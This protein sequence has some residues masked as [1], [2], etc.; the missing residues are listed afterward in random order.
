[1][2]RK[3]SKEEEV[4][5]VEKAE[6][7]S[8]SKNSKL[9]LTMRE[10]NKKFGE[11]SI[12]SMDKA[13]HTKVKVIPTGS[14]SLDLALGVGG[15]PRGRII[16]IYGPES[17]GKTTLTLSI[18]ASAQSKGLTV[19]YIDAE[20]AMDTSYAQKVGVD[21]SKLKFAQ[22]N[23]GE[24]ALEILEALTKSGTIGLII[25]DSVAALIPQKEL[26]GEMGD[27]TMGMQARLMSQAM[28]KICG[29]A[30]DTETCIIFINQLRANI[31][32]YGNPEVTSG[33]KALKYAASIRI[34]LRTAGKDKIMNGTACIGN[35]VRSTMKKNKLSPPFAEAEF[36][37]IFGKGVD[38]IKDLLDVA[39]D[40]GVLV[41]TSNG[42]YSWKDKQLG[43]GV[44]GMRELFS[45]DNSLEKEIKSAVLEIIGKD[46]EING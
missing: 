40:V 26:D 43:H 10:I 16:E 32:G 14:L 34:D 11:G 38:S 20:H 13:L 4:E 35:R 44:D 31:G 17:S 29:A 19:A 33:G 6:P 5:A 7:S 23:S 46:W 18:V 27:P 25:V 1:M 9:E 21:I 36:D 28:R 2:V 37:I 39:N 3:S 22:P 30:A 12:I 42:W 41:K 24:Q 45:Q 8:S 15:V